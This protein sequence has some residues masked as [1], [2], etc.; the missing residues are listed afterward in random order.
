MKQH[1]LILQLF[2]NSKLIHVVL[3]ALSNMYEGLK[4]SY[5]FL[6][7]QKVWDIKKAL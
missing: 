5:S 2:L 3:Y 4:N 1:E 7:K 6:I